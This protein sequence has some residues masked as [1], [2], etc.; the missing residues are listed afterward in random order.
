MTIA[1]RAAGKRWRL[2]GVE[3]GTHRSTG[4]STQSSFENSAS[5]MT[6][7]RGKVELP[8]DA[9]TGPCQDPDP[10]RFTP[11]RLAGGGGYSPL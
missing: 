3:S 9:S 6:Q 2:G 8:D 11:P 4:A 1:E 5:R 10:T 7:K